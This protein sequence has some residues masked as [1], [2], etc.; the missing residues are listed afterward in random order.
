M[1]KF[2]D[3]EVVIVCRYL[4]RCGGVTQTGEYSVSLFRPI[5]NFPK[6]MQ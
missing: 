4:L 1:M 6:F 2:Y 5:K 3:D